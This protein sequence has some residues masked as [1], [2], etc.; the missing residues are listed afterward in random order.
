MSKP[1]NV[2][3]FPASGTPGRSR[4]E[5]GTSPTGVAMESPAHNAVLVYGNLVSEAL[6]TAQPV[7]HP[8]K[9]VELSAIATD[10]NGVYVVV[11]KGRITRPVTATTKAS[12]KFASL[13]DDFGGSALDRIFL[14]DERLS[15]GVRPEVIYE[16]ARQFAEMHQ[17]DA[18]TCRRLS[19]VCS[20]L[21]CLHAGLKV[22][23]ME[24]P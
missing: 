10:G 12:G 16:N 1:Y 20:L 8:T 7:P 19:E 13:G 14:G 18:N 11:P 9:T 2:R 23:P 6:A 21:V 24:L 15:G 22:A 17:L 5:I 3:E 4:F